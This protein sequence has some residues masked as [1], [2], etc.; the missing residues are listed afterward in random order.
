LGEELGRGGMGIVY[1]ARDTVLQRSLAVKVLLEVHADRPDL[2][3][4]FLEEAQVLGQYQ[5]P[6]IPPV[7]ALGRLPDGRPY[8]A[9]KLVKGHTLTDLLAARANP[10]EDQARFLGIFEQVCQALAHAH[11]KRVIHRDLKPANVM[12]GA[13]GEVQVVDWGLAKV[14][15]TQEPETSEAEAG[16]RGPHEVAAQALDDEGKRAVRITTNGGIVSPVIRA[17]TPGRH[18]TRFPMPDQC[19]PGAFLPVREPVAP[20]PW[21]DGS[22]ARHGFARPRPPTRPNRAHV[23]SHCCNASTGTETA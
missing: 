21:T 1:R 4:R 22:R 18:L 12:V 19:T 20:S 11:S 7:H 13:F 17:L 10:A 9:M 23:L 2:E 5:H 6:A 3:R 8:F 14:L 15:G 16:H